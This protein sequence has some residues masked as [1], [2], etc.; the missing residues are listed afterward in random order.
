MLQNNQNSNLNI[1][2]FS[3]LSCFKLGQNAKKVQVETLYP[4]L[5]QP[6]SK[7]NI[8]YECITTICNTGTVNGENQHGVSVLIKSAVSSSLQVNTDYIITSSLSFF[9]YF[10]KVMYN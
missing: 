6:S 9:L 8:E 3:T 4:V 10:T 5:F 7:E 1:L 2:M